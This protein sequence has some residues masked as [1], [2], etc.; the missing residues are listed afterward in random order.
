MRKL[1]IN[2]CD[3]R[4]AIFSSVLAG[5]IYRFGFPIVE[6][7]VNARDPERTV[8]YFNYNPIMD[9]IATEFFDEHKTVEELMDEGEEYVRTHKSN[10]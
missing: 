5:L 3:N 8:Y 7:Q 1:K 4:V 9:Y 2:P 10:Y 6:R